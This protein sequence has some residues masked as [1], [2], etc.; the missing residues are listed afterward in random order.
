MTLTR[1]TT[2]SLAL[3]PLLFA[4]CSGAAEPTVIHR[5]TLVEARYCGHGAAQ[6][7][8]QAT[9]DRALAG[10]A[11][12]TTEQVDQTLHDEA[13]ANFLT[14]A[15][16][17]RYPADRARDLTW[18]G[19]PH[20]GEPF[21][22]PWTG[23]AEGVP[24]EIGEGFRSSC[25]WRVKLVPG[26]PCP[27]HEHLEE[28]WQVVIAARVLSAADYSGQRTFRANSQLQAAI[29]WTAVDCVHKALVTAGEENSLEFKAIGAAR[30][31]SLLHPVP[32]QFE[33]LE[34]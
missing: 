22:E 32:P 30:G 10:I 8:L 7:D 28:E 15:A 2:L 6:A 19:Q 21:P 1:T 4:G 13:V 31:A 16:S 33:G 9:V 26:E 14:S 5:E 24:F 34:E 29:A 20:D 3:L 25:T 18:A 11:A 12:P 23:D 17:R 27:E